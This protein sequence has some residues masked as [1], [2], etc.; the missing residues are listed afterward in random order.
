MP[1][2]GIGIN[3]RGYPL[4]FIVFYDHIQ[5]YLILVILPNNLEPVRDTTNNLR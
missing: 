4:V 5:S 3:K 1:L 2:V